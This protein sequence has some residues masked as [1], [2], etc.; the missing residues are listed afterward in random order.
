MPQVQLLLAQE[1]FLF[2]IA[3]VDENKKLIWKGGSLILRRYSQ[4]KPPRFTSDIDFTLKDLIISQG[5]DLIR[6]AA[7]LDLHDGF[8]FMEITQF[9][10]ERDTPYGG[11]RFEVSWQF[12]GK[13][14][15]EALRIDLCAGDDVDAERIQLNEVYLLDDDASDASLAVY[16]PEFI[17]A[18]KLETL[19]RFGTGNTRLKDFIDLWTLAQLPEKEL[20]RKS[21]IAAIQRCFE[22]RETKL[23]EN[24]WNEILRDIEFQELMETARTRNFSK[25][26]IPSVQKMFTVISKFLVDLGPWKE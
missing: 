8:V 6:A 10:M 17:F 21:C 26:T 18:E 1:R 23:R 25:L 12:Q 22:R 24:D 3:R 9:P 15:S 4:L 2:R 7:K 13:R 20:P 19:V 16:P 11:E 14:N 5:E